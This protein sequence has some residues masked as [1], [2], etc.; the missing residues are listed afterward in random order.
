LKTLPEKIKPFTIYP[1]GKF[2][3][4][5]D[6]FITL[7]VILSCIIA[8]YMMAFS[9]GDN[10][11]SG[12]F[13]LDSTINILFAID[14]VLRFFTAYIDDD[15]LELRDAKVDIA[16]DYVKGWFF[17]DLISVIPFDLIFSYS[18]VNRITRFSRLGRIS[19]IV[20][21]I[22]M[23]RLLKIAKVHSKLMKNFQQVVQIAG[24]LERL[25]FLLLIF[26]I[27]IHVIA[28]LWIFIAKFDE[29]SKENWIYSK[30]FV[31]MGNYDL[32][33][34]SFYF[35]VTTI[36]TVG[37]GDITAISSTEKIVAVFL[38]IIGVIAFSFATGALS[39]IIANIDQSEAILKEKMATL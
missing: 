20:R 39:S 3:T 24:G 13:Y 35:S 22:K 11:T 19:K 28:C 36:V 15:S 29:G 16:M 21:M 25:V 12:L 23:V 2:S 5:W 9:D 10:T 6:L 34:T 38:M 31:D 18:N 1:D 30:N 8:P 4:L 32:Y 7:L 27:L 14:I 37:Y 33:V 26:L 17:I